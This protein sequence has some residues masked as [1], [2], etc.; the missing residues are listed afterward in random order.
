MPET[1]NKVTTIT[2]LKITT[3][4]DRALMPGE[5]AEQVRTDL[6]W[7]G[8]PSVVETINHNDPNA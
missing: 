6:I 4:G 5:L 2:Y 7:D 1:S 3:T 8:Y